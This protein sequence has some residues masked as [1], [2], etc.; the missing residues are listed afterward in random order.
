[1]PAAP[2]TWRPTRTGRPAA[3]SHDVPAIGFVLRCRAWGTP[4]P[5]LRDARRAESGVSAGGGSQL[6]MGRRPRAVRDQRRFQLVPRL[7]MARILSILRGMRTNQGGG[8]REGER[9]VANLERAAMI[10]GSGTPGHRR[11]S[12]FA[13]LLTLIA[14][15]V[16]IALSPAP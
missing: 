13:G 6:R 11:S 16:A 10:A 8:K 4:V 7:Q 14:A 3:R 2:G 12:V 9:V 15:V 1:M 5:A